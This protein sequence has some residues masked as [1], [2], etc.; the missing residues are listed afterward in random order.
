MLILLLWIR[1]WAPYSLDI[2]LFGP[3]QIFALGK[4]SFWFWYML[5]TLA[6]W[7]CQISV[8]SW[9]NLFLLFFEEH[10]LSTTATVQTIRPRSLTE[11]SAPGKSIMQ[12]ASSLAL[13]ICRSLFVVLTA[14]AMC[15]CWC[16]SWQSCCCEQCWAQCGHSQGGQCGHSAGQGAGPGVWLLLWWLCLPCP[17]PFSCHGLG[18]VQ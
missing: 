1:S 12:M 2:F 5:L 17:E 6:K 8:V 7:K 9:W 16:N 10:F 13:C 18:C 3:E 15:L 14:P 4:L 11:T